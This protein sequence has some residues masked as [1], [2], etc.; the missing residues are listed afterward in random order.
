MFHHGPRKRRWLIHDKDGHFAAEFH[1]E[2]SEEADAVAKIW[3]EH[4]G[5][6]LVM[7]WDPSPEDSEDSH[8]GYYRL[9]LNGS[10]WRET[11]CCGWHSMESAARL[12]TKIRNAIVTHGIETVRSIL[13]AVSRK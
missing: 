7:G 9:R 6:E 11:V 10:G 13:D 1:G 12:A 3:N 2:T 5:S 4:D 8:R